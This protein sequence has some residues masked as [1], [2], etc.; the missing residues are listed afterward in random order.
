MLPGAIALLL[1]GCPGATTPASRSEPGSAA[2]NSASLPIQQAN[3]KSSATPSTTTERKVQLSPIP[4]VATDSSANEKE[5]VRQAVLNDP[6]INASIQREFERVP[7]RNPEL[8]HPLEVGAIAIVGDYAL[9][10]YFAGIGDLPLEGIG[11][12]IRQNG[13]WIMLDDAGFMGEILTDRMANLGVPAATI[14][15]LLNAFRQAGANFEVSDMSA[16]ES[17]MPCVTWLDD[18]NPPTN[19]RLAPVVTPDNVIGQLPNGTA[20]TVLESLNGWLK[21]RQPRVGWVSMNLTRVSCGDSLAEVQRNLDELQVKEEELVVEA[22]DTLVRYLYRGADGV[23][24]EAAI[25][26]FNGFAIERFYALEAALDRHTEEVRRRV[27]Q[28]VI[29]PGMHPQARA[30]FD[31]ALLNRAHLSPTLKTWRSLNP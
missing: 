6:S 2:S 19:V 10:E 8:L 27:L 22:A 4:T 1:T 17:K 14:Q 15:P 11:L 9:A 16:R 31:D 20:L 7:G 18:P 25:A 26:R 12:L 30:S 5:A 23:F 3:L 28:Q 29:A 21:I 24:A 13:R